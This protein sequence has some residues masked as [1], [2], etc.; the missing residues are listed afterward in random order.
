MEK[1][2]LIEYSFLGVW[3]T[4]FVIFIKENY[5]GVCIILILVSPSHFLCS[6]NA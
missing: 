1:V 4:D 6:E 5:S 3:P 2:S